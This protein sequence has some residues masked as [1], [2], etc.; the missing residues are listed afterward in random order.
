MSKSRYM[1][2][3]VVSLV[4]SYFYPIT[5]ENYINNVVILFSIIIVGRVMA[6]DLEKFIK[7]ERHKRQRS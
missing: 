3:L 2:A 5:N 1:A 7:N 6:T 4:M